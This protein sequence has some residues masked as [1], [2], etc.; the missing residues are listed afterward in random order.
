[1]YVVYVEWVEWRTGLPKIVDR[2]S[3]RGRSKFGSDEDH[4]GFLW[5]RARHPVKLKQAHAYPWTTAGP[6]VPIR[7]PNTPR[8]TLARAGP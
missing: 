7:V 8:D 5:G 3:P 1:M 6:R 2:P 4:V